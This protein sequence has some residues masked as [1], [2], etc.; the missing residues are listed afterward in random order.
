MIALLLTVPPKV[1]SV[2]Q[3]GQ[4]FFAQI[5]ATTVAKSAS[6][7]PST[8]SA[9]ADL[10]QEKPNEAKTGATIDSQFATKADPGLYENTGKLRIATTTLEHF[11]ETPVSTSTDALESNLTINGGITAGVLE[12]PVNVGILN[13]IKSNSNLPAQ[14]EQS[15]GRQATSETQQISA[16]APTNYG[17]IVN[18]HD[19]ESIDS[20]PQFS[21]IKQG[22]FKAAQLNTVLAAEQQVL[23]VA[24]PDGAVRFAS[25]FG[26][27]SKIKAANLSTLLAG[28][29]PQL[30]AAY[31][32]AEQPEIPTSIDN[33]NLDSIA[34]LATQSKY[35]AAKSNSIMAGVKPQ[36]TPGQSPVEQT[37]SPAG[38]VKN[39][40][41]PNSGTAKQS[42]IKAAKLSS[43][44]AAVK[45]QLS[46]AQSSTDQPESFTGE[47]DNDIN[48]TSSPDKLSKLKAANLG[49]ALAG[50]TASIAAADVIDTPHLV[51][52]TPEIST[53]SQIAPVELSQSA[54][55][56]S[57]TSSSKS[58]HQQ[59]TKFQQSTVAPGGTETLTA[60]EESA[61][62]TTA[63]QKIKTELNSQLVSEQIN[64][65]AT[66]ASTPNAWQQKAENL[67][68]GEIRQDLSSDDE[69][70]QS[71]LSSEI[72]VTNQ[73]SSSSFQ[74]ELAD[75]NSQQEQIFSR[76]NETNVKPAGP[77]GALADTSFV[78]QATMGL[79]DGET[80]ASSIGIEPKSLKVSAA[81]GESVVNQVAET[82][83]TKAQ[84]LNSDGNK[85]ITLQINPVE[86]GKL[87]IHVDST[88]DAMKA[89]IFASELATS[90]L[91][92]REQQ[93]LLNSLRELGI[94]LPEVEVSY[95][96]PGTQA[97]K[98]QAES[99]NHSQRE[100]SYE[101]PTAQTN[102][103]SETSTS[104]QE[105][106]STTIDLVA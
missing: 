72:E 5:P 2:I 57:V 47:I 21:Q 16:A 51:S 44:L 102:A 104:H 79:P 69:T 106:S 98:Q 64:R 3:L 38:E 55:P 42:K 87:E 46:V 65:P 25:S 61:T 95:Q 92:V 15:N 24:E 19:V 13:T 82:I 59:Y 50:E 84:V 6:Q 14:N 34:Y 17:D 78:T 18:I 39:Y 35:K 80:V 54:A 81:V 71:T 105:T 27:A 11:S 94:D 88:T 26:K 28:V 31:S 33:G 9:F 32:T 58:K 83:I 56:D 68:S 74:I 52:N 96:D 40:F 97:D 73:E 1:F 30:L 53:N 37:E 60:V 20:T 75:S 4:A 70:S 36:L 93:Q 76:V 89:Q 67:Q 66:A 103:A 43:L 90:E 77:L 85:K 63:E 7:T 12:N 8:E 62:V 91:L 101:T 86:L 49:S 48:S 45:P 41:E 22:K 100:T 29:K 10:H 23:S 99:R